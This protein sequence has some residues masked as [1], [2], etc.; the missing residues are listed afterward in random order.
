MI[1]G[2]RRASRFVFRA[3]RGVP[4]SSNLCGSGRSPSRSRPSFSRPDL[5]SLYP[6]YAPWYPNIRTIVV[7]R[8]FVALPTLLGLKTNAVQGFVLLVARMP[9]MGLRQPASKRYP[10]LRPEEP[11]GARPMPVTRLTVTLGPFFFRDEL[12]QPCDFLP[13]IVHSSVVWQRHIRVRVR[14]GG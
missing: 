8:R 12:L 6:I 7:A 11:N 2:T 14:D 1:A 3:G 13:Q 9:T 5:N 4:Q 10:P